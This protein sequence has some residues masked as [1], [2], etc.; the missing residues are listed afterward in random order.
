MDEWSKLQDALI[1]KLSAIFDSILKT[2]KAELSEVFGNDL[3]GDPGPRA[4]SRIPTE[5]EQFLRRLFDGFLEIHSAIE[6]L[7]DIELYI[8]RF[9]YPRTRVTKQ[10]ATAHGRCA[11]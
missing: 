4:I 7:Q 9:P 8:A 5:R 6:I 3:P 10:S 1:A 11:R 2:H